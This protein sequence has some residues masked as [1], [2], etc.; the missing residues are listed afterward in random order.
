MEYYSLNR[1]LQDTFGHKIY[2]ISLDGGFTCPNRD[3][4]LDTR[5]CIFCS[6]AGSGE[7]AQS[8]KDSIWQQMEKGKKRLKDKIQNG[9]YIAYFQAFTNTY[10]P[11]ERLRELYEDAISHPDT[12]ILSI[13][14]RPDCLSEKVLLLL[15]EMNEKKPVWIELGLQTIHETSAEYIRRGYPLSVYDEAVNNL[16]KIGVQVIVHVILGLPGETSEQMKETVSYVAKSGADGIKLQLLHV[17]KGTDLEK[18]YQAGKF[19]TLEMAEYVNLV[20]DCIALLPPDMV[21][22]RL[23]GDGDRKTLVAP[24]WSLHKK[25]V[26]NAINQKIKEKE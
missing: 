16:K 7:F 19:R 15:Q 24:L 5:G 13:A 20:A 2:K 22:H 26:L 11:V 3:G 14:T 10:A 9:K 4:T 25:R 17:I 21:I 8:R 1:Y 23:T 6:Q 12:A 18:D